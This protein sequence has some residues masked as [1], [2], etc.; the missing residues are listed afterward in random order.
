M[1]ITVED[2]GVGFD[3]NK[4]R[5]QANKGGFGLPSINERLEII[6]AYYPT[7][8]KFESEQKRGTSISIEITVDTFE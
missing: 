6:R 2:D 8:L 7:K 4:P 1:T 5:D 3:V